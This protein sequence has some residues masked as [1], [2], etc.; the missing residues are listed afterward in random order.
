MKMI[1]VLMTAALIFVFVG[2][3][4]AETYEYYYWNSAVD[5]LLKRTYKDNG[6][7]YEYLNEPAFPGTYYGRVSLLYIALDGVYKTYDWL[8][9]DQAQVYEYAGIYDPVADSPIRSAIIPAQRRFMYLYDHHGEMQNIGSGWTLREKTAYDI[10]GS[11]VLY[12]EE[13]LTSDF[14]IRKEADGHVYTY[15]YVGG[16]W[17]TNTQLDPDGTVSIYN[18]DGSY[19]F[20][21]VTKYYTNGNVEKLDASLRLTEKTEPSGNF[22]KGGNL[23]WMDYGYDVGS[24][25]ASYGFSLGAKKKELIEKLSD[26]SGGT[27][28]LFL[29]TDLRDVV[30]FSG[31]ALAFYDETKLFADMDA[32][33]EAAKIA[34]TKLIPTLF[35]YMI[36][37]GVELTAEHPEVIT[38][39]VKRG[40]L[41]ALMATF[42][43]HYKN[44]D[45]IAMWDLM[46]EPFWGTDASV[47]HNS[48]VPVSDMITFLNELMATVRLSDP[49]K[50]ITIGFEHKENLDAATGYWNT[51]VDG[52][53]TNDVDV[54]QIHYWGKYYGDTFTELGY[55]ATLDPFGYFGGKPV[56]IGEIDPQYY[57]PGTDPDAAE[58]LDAI[59]G[60]GYIGGLFWQDESTPM[61]IDPA[62]LARIQEW[63]YGTRY[64]YYTDSPYMMHTKTMPDG[65]IFEYTN[66]D[67]LGDGYGMLIKETAPT[68]YYKTFEDYYA[69]TRQWRYIKSYNPSDVL[70]VTYEYDASGNL[71]RITYANVDQ[72]FYPSGNLKKETYPDGNIYEY[73]D[74]DYDNGD[75]VGRMYKR[76]LP[77]GDYYLSPNDSDFISG[78]DAA[79]RQ[80]KHLADGTL[81]ESYV[82]TYNASWYLIQK[83]IYD[84]SGNLVE[85][86]VITDHYP[87]YSIRSQDRYTAAGVKIATYVIDEYYAGTFGKD[88]IVFKQTEYDGSGNFVGA[89]QFYYDAVSGLLVTQEIYDATYTNYDGKFTY[90]YFPGTNII[91]YKTRY[92]AADNFVVEYEYDVDSHLIKE[93]QADGSYKEFSDYYPGTNQWRYIREY[94]SSGVLQVTYEFDASGNLIGK[95]DAIAIYTYYVPSGRMHTKELSVDE[96][97]NLA[98]TIFEYSDDPVHNVGTPSEY[99]Y[100]IKQTNPDGSYKTF[101]DYYAGTTQWR[102]IN[103]YDNTG[104]LLVTYEYDIDGHL[105]GK[106]VPGDAVY[107]YYVPTGRMHTKTLIDN[108]VYEYDDTAV[109]D[110]GTPLDPTDD[111]GHLIKKTNPDLS[112]TEYSDFWS[113]DIARYVR[114]YDSGGNLLVTYEY[115]A[116]GIMISKVI[117]G[118]ESY[119][120]YPLTGRMHTKT[121][122][123][124]TV[125]EYDDTA[126]HDN[127]TPLDPTDDYGHL[128]KK[129]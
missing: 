90:T 62:D 32:L 129:T 43:D 64:T 31:P 125:Y 113:A 95:T 117:E 13:Y 105:I 112:Y 54:V 114:D 21:G 46:N 108:T 87:D 98:G 81:V 7:I 122:I 111:Y 55:D 102:Y 88:K 53:G 37:D 17:Y 76:T 12:T 126:V 33:L 115:N 70:L 39:P 51:F 18:Y 97:P 80:E 106:T 11:T 56:F 89:Y 79:R 1:K 59:F 96:L 25:N 44:N 38:D 86:Y 47:W 72:E 36:S 100:L 8:V 52:V 94:D 124:N 109:H 67:Y 82:F 61:P 50:A 22:M 15:K 127:G 110:N 24:Q 118:G 26:F 77:N 45:Q 42:V 28:R 65:T 5:Y 91:Q 23:P 128:I 119:T 104:T 120:Y 30:D 123:D 35:D 49:G 3:A 6:D 84:A 58:R 34:G 92:D 107:T 29:F 83:D 57:N 103:E 63:Y 71:V 93:T 16:T 68:G 99:G 85:Y 74:N 27:V 4:L 116:S 10:D 121:L 101:M 2:T 69:G 14:Y 41:M 19:V 66:E 40:E 73:Q 60:A 48:I 9:G 20:Q 75:H 78:H